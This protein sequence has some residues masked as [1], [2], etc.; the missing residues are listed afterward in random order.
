[1]NKNRGLRAV[2]AGLLTLPMA[3]TV[4]ML[5]LGSMQISANALS[6][7]IAAGISAILCA[8]AAQGGVFALISA[9]L[10]GVALCFSFKSLR[11]MLIAFR[12]N[13]LPGSVHVTLA[14]LAAFLFAVCFFILLHRRGGSIFAILILTLITVL[15]YAVNQTMPL[16]TAVPG[17]IAA[18]IAF[19][20]DGRTVQPGDI[21][22]AL[23]PAALCVVLAV[24]LVPSEGLTWKPLRDAANYVQDLFEEYFRFTEERVPFTINAEGYD[25]AA[26]VDGVVAA[27]LGGPADPDTEPVM[28]VTSDVD[29]LLRGSIRRTYTG[30]AWTDSAT[31]S[32]Y[33]YLD[34][35]RIS[36]RESLLGMSDVRGFTATDVQIEFLAEGTSTLFVPARIRDFSMNLQNAVYYNS[37]GELF[38]TRTVVAGDAY[39]IKAVVENE[40]TIRANMGSSVDESAVEGCLQLPDGI[41][42]GVYSLTNSIIEN[43][44]TDYDRARAIEAWLKGNCVYT[45]KPDYPDASRDFVSQ[46]V[47]DTREGYCSYF[48]SAM[49]VMCRIAG[50][51]ARYIEGYYARMNGADSMILTGENAHAWTEV[52]IGNVGWVT[53]NPSGGDAF[54]GSGDSPEPTESPESG[55]PDATVPPTD[56]PTPPPDDGSNAPEP[57]SAPTPEPTDSFIDATQPP[58]GGESTPEPTQ[59]PQGVST[60]QNRSGGFGKWILILLAILLLL[61][62]ILILV[63]RVLSRMHATDPLTLT[64]KANA[65]TAMLLLYRACLTVL[66]ICGLVPKNGETPKDFANRVNAVV[67]NADFMQFASAL[68]SVV[69]A[70]RP[71]G[72]EGVMIGRKAYQKFCQSLNLRKK[73]KFTL[74]R[75]FKGLGD[76]RQIP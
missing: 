57:T 9:V 43:C 75:I 39:S 33:L 42:S 38:L 52:Y 11:E 15:S 46:F 74:R 14:A 32:R 35:S 22:R 65:E 12:T 53:F 36:T 63:K 13:N 20:A 29:L 1:M 16:G 28:R 26:E 27:R 49:T 73:I 50:V 47:L 62:L 4:T 70:N 61:L 69:Y 66:S 76:Y 58:E 18:V 44:E 31:K 67:V 51:P 45:L 23:I 30:N 48:A 7:Y 6:V 10:A 71:A 64:A 24:L 72:R 3:A 68:E 40:E 25:S 59:E 34:F 56:E 5:L 17:L 19:A 54:G 21:L 2:I 41:E 55:D 60:T 37:I 8:L